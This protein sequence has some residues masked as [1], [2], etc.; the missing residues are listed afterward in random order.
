MASEDVK[1]CQKLAAK[2][3]KLAKT[4]TDSMDG[5]ADLTSV[6]QCMDALLATQSE[7][8]IAFAGVAEIP[9]EA[10]EQ[11]QQVLVGLRQNVAELGQQVTTYGSEQG[12]IVPHFNDNASVSG[13]AH[14]GASSRRNRAQAARE[15]AEAAERH[16]LI[17]VE[18]QEL[19]RQREEFQ[20]LK[21]EHERAV[22]LFRAEQAAAKAAHEKRLAEMEEASE[23]SAGG[24]HAVDDVTLPKQRL[25]AMQ[26]SASVAGAESN[27]NDCRQNEDSGAEIERPRARTHQRHHSLPG[28]RVIDGTSAVITELSGDRVSPQ[29]RLASRM[30]D[31]TTWLQK[32]PQPTAGRQPQQTGNVHVQNARPVRGAS[33]RNVARRLDAGDPDCGSDSQQRSAHSLIDSF[34]GAVNLGLSLPPPEIPK[35]SGSPL[36]YSRFMNTFQTAIEAKVT[37][38]NMRLMYLTQHCTGEARQAIQMCQLLPGS[39]GYQKAKRI[40]QERFG[41][42]HQVARA[43]IDRVVSGPSIPGSDPKALNKFVVDLQCVYITL[44]TQDYA[45]ELDSVVTLQ[46]IARRLPYYI[47]TRWSELANEM[48]ERG[49]NPSFTDLLKLV[50]SKARAANSPF[51]AELH[52]NESSRSRPSNDNRQRSSNDRRDDRQRATTL[53][54]TAQPEKEQRQ[55]PCLACSGQCKRLDQCREFKNFPMVKRRDIVFRHRGCLNC[56]QIGHFSSRCRAPKACTVP[57]CE[58]KHHTLMHRFYN[59]DAQEADAPTAAKK[60]RFGARSATPPPAP[61][62][63]SAPPLPSVHVTA[64]STSGS[65]LGVVPVIV[66]ANG[67]SVQTYA[68]LDNG[69]DKTLVTDRL[70]SALGV[71]GSPVDFTISGVNID[72]V[73]YRGKQVDLK[74]RPLTGTDVLDVRRAWSVNALPS[75]DEP[76]PTRAALQRWPHMCDIE[77]TRIPGA[78]VS[79]LIGNDVSAAHLPYEHRSGTDAEPYALKTALGWAVRGPREPPKSRRGSARARNVQSCLV[80]TNAKNDLCSQVK[81]YFEADFSED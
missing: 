29:K 69:S 25:R 11:L 38:N 41:R 39:S 56:L 23:R 8:E 14:A 10:Q 54:A 42:E 71:E 62:T 70:I 63:P 37:D 74:V 66:E 46:R 65:Y 32:T 80:R 1:T 33:A 28:Q 27:G 19:D 9:D 81:A 47:R 43:C 77:L 76:L 4:L 79:L 3:K 35:F 18:R 17:L 15:N 20:R 68:L 72:S 22:E 60:F 2:A 50:D 73:P 6:H 55:R 67:A 13:D 53:A 40:L 58:Y 75:P 36:E 21:L 26:S 5:H 59:V 49:V 44:S 51:G 57:G 24:Q 16:R 45:A 34:A 52:A 12:E 61:L 30:T 78:T 48:W 64:T 31:V 7:F